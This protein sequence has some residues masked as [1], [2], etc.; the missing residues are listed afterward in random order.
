[1]KQI[2]LFIL[3]GIILLGIKSQ[4]QIE[5][6]GERT[7]A[8]TLYYDS[9]VYQST[10]T[11]IIKDKQFIN[12]IAKNDTITHIVIIYPNE[13]LDVIK[14]SFNTM[15]LTR[16]KYFFEYQEGLYCTY[17]IELEDSNYFGLY[18]GRVE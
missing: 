4:A 11:L 9:I 8:P 6:I 12:F 3:F 14:E 16:D 7:E 15:I 5:F 13:L 10:D 1:M 2:K 17:I 18:L